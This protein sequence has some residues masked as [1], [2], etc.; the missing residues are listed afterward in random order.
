MGRQKERAKKWTH[1][2][3]ETKKQ[4]KK[5][6]SVRVGNSQYEI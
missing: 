5:E 4:E 6:K 1:I 2:N 3:S